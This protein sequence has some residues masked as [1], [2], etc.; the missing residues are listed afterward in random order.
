MK[1][2]GSPSYINIAPMPLPEAYVSITNILFRS[3][4][5]KTGGW[6]INCFSFSK[7]PIASVFHKKASFLSNCVNGLQINP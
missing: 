3:G 2:S 1:V 6:V 7:A 5:A 4:K